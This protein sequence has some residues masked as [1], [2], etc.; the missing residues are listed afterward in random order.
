MK[1]SKFFTIKEIDQIH[2]SSLKILAEIGILVRSEKAR[3]IFAR[4]GCK[5]DAS[6]GIVKLPT[7]IV[8]EFQAGFAPSFTFRGRDPQFDR[9]IPEDSPVMVTASSAPNIIDPLTGRE[10]P[11]TSTDIANIAFLINELPGYDVFSIST[12]ADDAPGPDSGTADHLHYR[13]GRF[14]GCTPGRADHRGDAG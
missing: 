7:G 4:H 13:P 14:S 12:L 3:S 9:T 5:V 2:E 11:A 6:S 8:D 10:R 1:F